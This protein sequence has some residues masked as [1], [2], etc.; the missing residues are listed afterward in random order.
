M[1]IRALCSCQ[2]QKA[3][4]ILDNLQLHHAPAMASI[5]TETRDKLPLF[6][7]QTPIRIGPGMKS[8]DLASCPFILSS[9]T[10]SVVVV[11]PAF[12]PERML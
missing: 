9:L 1:V 11:A 6:R 8:E 2:S 3:I 10:C 5:F 12:L 4:V 7:V